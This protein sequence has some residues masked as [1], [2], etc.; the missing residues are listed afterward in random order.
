MHAR[1]PREQTE[2]LDAVLNYTV[3]HSSKQTCDYCNI[4][5]FKKQLL[6]SKRLKIKKHFKTQ[7]GGVI[8]VTA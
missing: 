6:F 4:S 3:K 1:V 8:V 2:C 5:H 7:D